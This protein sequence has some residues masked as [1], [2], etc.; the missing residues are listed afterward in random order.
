MESR[1]IFGAIGRMWWILAITVIVGI[2]AGILATTLATP[3]YTATTRL[4]VSAAGGSSS[5]ESES[6]GLFSVQRT[7]SYAHMIT[8]E[9]VAQRVIDQLGLPMSA[10]EL[11]SKVTAAVVPRTVLFDVSA[12]DPSPDRAAEIANEFANTFTVYAGALETPVGATSPRVTVTVFSRAKAPSSP[13]SPTPGKNVFY[14]V[15]GGIGVGLAAI[16]LARVFSRRIHSADELGRITGAPALGPITPIPDVDD[17]LAHL[18]AWDTRVTEDLRRLRVEIDAQDPAPRVVL[19]TSASPGNS[20]IPFGV[21]LAVAFC[22][23]GCAT[24]LIVADAELDSRSFG[25]GLGDGAP[26]LAE[27]LKGESSFDEVLR[28]TPRSNLFLVLTARPRARRARAS[29]ADIEPLLSSTVMRRFVDDLRREFDRVV[30]VTASI[31]AS[32]AASV[33]SAIVDA[34]L[35]VVNAETARRSHVERAMSELKAARAHLLGAVLVK[36]GTPG[37]RWK[38]I[39][40]PRTV[41]RS[42]NEQESSR[43][44]PINNRLPAGNRS[45]SL[46]RDN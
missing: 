7:E 6:G 25:S 17:G 34:D 24:A 13:I 18:A 8:T 27:L 2:L 32:S 45:E 9:Q 33:L 41:D 15:A 26:G 44:Y 16:A 39:R 35:L 36:A 22:E 40:R 30:I 29:A 11:S 31:N 42:L 10:G 28:P 14:G 5:S 12:T 23:T 21:G 4:F 20:A 3:E 19:A 37:G 43:G 46:H 38:W 1:R